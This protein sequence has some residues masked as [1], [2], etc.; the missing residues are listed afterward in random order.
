LTIVERRSFDEIQQKND[1]DTQ[2]EKE[3]KKK[4]QQ[5]AQPVSILKKGARPIPITQFGKPVVLPSSDNSSADGDDSFASGG[6]DPDMVEEKHTSKNNDDGG[7]DDELK[8][9]NTAKSGMRSGRYASA[10]A[11]AKKKQNDDD[12]ND[13]GND[14]GNDSDYT[15]NNKDDE[16]FYDYTSANDDDTNDYSNDD[17]THNNDDDCT[18]N[19]SNYSD[20]ENT[21]KSITTSKDANF[22]RSQS[23]FLRTADLGLTQDTIF[24]EQFLDDSNDKAEPH[25]H[26]PSPHPPPGV[27]FH[28]DEN[29]VSLDD[30][31]G[32]HSP[33]APQAVDALVAMGYRAACD[34]MMW[35]P[36]SKT[37]KYMTE[38]KLRFDDIP[39]P[40][41]LEE[42]EGNA[43][44]KDGAGGSC[45]V[46]SGKFPHK[47]HG[48]EQPAIRSQGIVN[49]SP[50]ELVDLLMDSS[51]VSEYNKSSIGRVDEVVLSD[52]NERPDGSCCPF[53]GQRK[54]KLT[55]VVM[56]GAKVVD[57]TAVFDSETD[58]EQSDVEEIE[59]V[60]FDDHGNK[61]VST[62]KTSASGKYSYS[63]GVQRRICNFLGVTKLVRT[64]NKPPLVRKVL[65]FNTLLHCRALTDDQGGDG[66]II[67]GRGI[68]PA[69][70]AER[71]S[72][73]KKG[74][75][76]SEILLNVHIVR[77]LRN[78]KKSKR[79][80]KK[81]KGLGVG[82][83]KNISVTGRKA[84]KGDLADRCLMIN[85]NHLK[86]PM[87]PNMLAKK[88]GLSGAVSF[89]TDIR[90]LTSE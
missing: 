42:G 63:T 9:V 87:V 58:D 36:T 22:D 25:Y 57:G 21:L 60:V 2:K 19:K 62:I 10:N 39:I 84:G 44:N 86:S 33:I 82:S 54:K 31:K 49:M 61:S 90:S 16:S 75:M 70:E 88:V 50:E 55:G 74:V 85:V 6:S 24:A 23:H 53:S 81:G 3:R 83:S 28:I 30:G 11:A 45:L 73:E 59:E 71:S 26:H 77:R 5:S 38:K 17:H 14:R 52:G 47:Y 18:N 15:G 37:R 78:E 7:E 48:H 89:I 56:A 34:P 66:Y 13:S 43:N 69:S 35:T 72:K 40:G 67:V 79:S 51:R 65:E 1:E 80:H 4:Q 68:T 76:H 20:D 8:S 27:Q 29:W 64:T 12:D 41:P 32:Q 46:W